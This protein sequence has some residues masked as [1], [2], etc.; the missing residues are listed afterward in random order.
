MQLT[1]LAAQVLPYKWTVVAKAKKVQSEVASYIED[2]AAADKFIFPEDP[3]S[4]ISSI[5]AQFL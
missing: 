1:Q 2:V 5:L 3:T 4:E